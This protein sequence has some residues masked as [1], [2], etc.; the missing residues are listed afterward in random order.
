M[1]KLKV[2]E[3]KLGSKQGLNYNSKL[4]SPKLEAI[5]LNVYP[6]LM[7]LVHLQ[8]HHWTLLKCHLH[9][10]PILLHDSSPQPSVGS[11]SPLLAFDSSGPP[12]RSVN[13]WAV[14]RGW[15][16]KHTLCDSSFPI[17]LSYPPFPHPSKGCSLVKLCAFFPFKTLCIHLLS[18]Q[19]Y[20]GKGYR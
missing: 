19:A 18:Y 15:T 14:L 9:L 2:W 17:V 12:D 3:K 5:P 11:R 13:P 20:P 6:K 4:L 7:R 10:S 1:E 16:G 8:F